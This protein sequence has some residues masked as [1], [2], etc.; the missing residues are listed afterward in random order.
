MHTA[1]DVNIE[2]FGR[3]SV[4]PN[5]SLYPLQPPRNTLASQFPSYPLPLSMLQYLQ[6]AL[7]GICSL[8]RVTAN[9]RPI[10]LEEEEFQKTPSLSIFRLNPVLV[11][12]HANT[13]HAE[14]G[15][16]KINCILNG[17]GSITTPDKMIC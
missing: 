7:L 8:A 9:E 4:H 1:H 17:E 2:T 16:I 5:S 6:T 13:C 12:A 3:L 15:E 10:I 11:Q 14:H